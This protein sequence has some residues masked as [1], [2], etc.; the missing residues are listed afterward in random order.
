MGF[1]H[2]ATK[3]Y[4][5]LLD[6]ERLKRLVDQILKYH[7]EIKQLSVDTIDMLKNTE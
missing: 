5:F 6:W 4:G 2:V 7:S 1:R 3:I